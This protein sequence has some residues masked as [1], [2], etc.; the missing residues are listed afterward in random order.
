M[1]KFTEKQLKQAAKRLKLAEIKDAK[2]KVKNK[3]FTFA[4]KSFD[5]V[6]GLHYNHT[7][8]KMATT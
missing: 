6:G 1:T 2:G 3:I 7:R 5:A 8:Q 4:A